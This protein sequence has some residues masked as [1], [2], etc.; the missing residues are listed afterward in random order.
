ME[1]PRALLEI[2]KEQVWEKIKALRTKRRTALRSDPPVE[3]YWNKLRP[4][5]TF[6]ILQGG[7]YAK[8]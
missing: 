2:K 3:I 8:Q 1:Y 6:S 5:N 7:N 4:K